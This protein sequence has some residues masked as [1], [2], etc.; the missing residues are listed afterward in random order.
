MAN[1]FKE[2][3]EFS[4]GHLHDMIA[5]Y[6][7]E[8]DI[9]NIKAIL[10]GIHYVATREEIQEE[11]IPA[12]QYSMEF[13]RELTNIDTMETFLEALKP[14]DYYEPVQAAM[15]DYLETK[16][17]T[18]METNLDK[19]YFGYL[20]SSIYPGQKAD[21]LFLEFVRI[22]IDTINL[23]TLF[24]FKFVK[25]T[26][27]ELQPFLLDGGLLFNLSKL[28]ELG[29]TRDFEE[30]IDK[31]KPSPIYQKIGKDLEQLKEDG[32]LIHLI[33]VLD[34]YFL[35]MTKR[36]AYTSPI[37]ILPVLDYFVRKE[38]EVKNI[39][40]IVRGKSRD[41]AHEIIQDMLVI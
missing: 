37:S 32:S 26:K 9:W 6:L 12:G 22:R 21:K 14:T 2:V 17:L 40:A 30:L 38:L 39:R 7:N 41:L 11:L 1:T 16:M 19:A 10:R 35:D 25:G 4:K 28:E 27:A 8:W 29:D 31:L 36:F 24:R 33:N 13:W 18:R 3:L 5:H 15:D 34:R 23:K 20:L